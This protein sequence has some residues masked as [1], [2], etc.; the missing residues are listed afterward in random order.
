MDGDNGVCD[1]AMLREKAF[2]KQ[3]GLKTEPQMGP[4]LSRKKYIWP[5]KV[6]PGGGGRL[7]RNALVLH[8]LCAQR[9]A[10]SD[11]PRVPTLADLS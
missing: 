10:D 1:G 5:W 3:G 11:A 2:E 9:R 4:Y 8:R 6:V 7:T